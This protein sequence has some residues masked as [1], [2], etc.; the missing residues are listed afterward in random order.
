MST[1]PNAIAQGSA[2][3]TGAS[4]GIGAIYADRLASQGYD[5]I[6]VA[7]AGERLQALAEQLR[8]QYGVQVDSLAADLTVPAELHAV[9]Q[10]LRS[11]TRISMLVNNAGMAD[12]GK[13]A[14]ADLARV[15]SMLQ[16]NIL[17]LTRLAAAAAANF[18]AQGRGTLI[19]IGSVVA[20]APEMFNAAYSASKAYVL[21]LSQSLQQELAASGVRVQAVLP[22]ITR[23]AIWERS[24]HSL[25][26]LPAQ[27]VMAA[28]EMVDAALAG[29]AQG[30]S[31]T[32]P[33]LPDSADWQ[34][35]L[36]ARQQLGPNLSHRHAAARFGVTRQ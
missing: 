11:D 4:S 3:I 21:S 31:V 15:D 24:G 30:E 27:M 9:E 14:E 20:L 28:E 1:Q 32:L 36:A 25:D 5:L 19:N 2:L 23:T 6:L 35:F 16:L 29:L 18:G 10:R 34:A 13:L 17:A 7:R 33:S 26:A 12:S 8:S 22:G